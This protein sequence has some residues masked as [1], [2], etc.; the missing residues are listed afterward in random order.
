M[1]TL[2]TGRLVAVAENASAATESRLAA[3]DAARAKHERALI[4]LEQQRRLLLAKTNRGSNTIEPQPD[5]S[6]QIPFDSIPFSDITS[7]GMGPLMDVEVVTASR[8]AESREEAPNVIYVFTH[9]QIKQRGYKFIKDILQV[10]PGFHV[11][12]STDY[13]QSIRG[14]AP[15]D[16]EKLTLMINGHIINGL[17]E[18]KFLDG[19]INFD[20][21]ERVEVIVGP[22]SVLYGPETTGGIVNLITR[23]PSSP[24]VHLTAGNHSFQSHTVLY[25]KQWDEDKSYMVSGSYVRQ[26]GYKQ[27]PSLNYHAY[28]NVGNTEIGGLRYPSHL[29]YAQAQMGETWFQFSSYYGN[30]PDLAITDTAISL[31]EDPFTVRRNDFVNS[32]LVRDNTSLTSDLSLHYEVSFDNKRFS[33]RAERTEIWSGAPNYD[34]T[35]N[36][37]GIEVGVKHQSEKNYLQAGIQ[38][39]YKEN[40]HNYVFHWDPSDP[41]KNSYNR[42]LVEIR[43]TQAAG[44]YISDEYAMHDKVKLVG[45]C[46]F[47]FDTTLDSSKVYISPRAA[48]IF[49]PKEAW[50]S[51]LMYNR[52]TRIPSPWMTPMNN[53]W[54]NG[55]PNA[56]LY[57]V[58]YSINPMAEHPEVLDAYEWQNIF[59]FDQL[60]TSINIYYQKLK[61]VVTWYSPYSNAGDFDGYG[62]EADATYQ[63]NPKMKIWGNLAHTQAEFSARDSSAQLPFAKNDN[64]EPLSVPFLT[65]N[66]GTDWYL[67]DN[68]HL[69]TT[70]R[71]FTRQPAYDRVTANYIYISNQFYLDTTLAWEGALHDNLDIYLTGMNLLNNRNY[72][73]Q[74]YVQGMYKPR[75]VSIYLSAS[76]RFK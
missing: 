45:A 40:S 56:S 7:M 53:L 71:Y 63:L 4:E 21:V 72:V 28:P 37:Y 69:S 34:L 39:K 61:D 25:A 3:I 38:Y 47:D 52:A 9:E 67:S 13:V 36:I 57:P 35:Q 70:L 51:K 43:D 49:R 54:G 10:V 2:C 42:N 8:K 22:G 26:D 30:V 74:Q 5:S 17:S 65:S 29:L 1:L 73:S 33:R 44:F 24:E 68:L 64:G 48:V 12:F 75:G 59:Y 19:P 14:I 6:T 23:T 55:N 16:N 31:G 11:S 15:M 32:F 66:V 20:I 27:D 76:Y 60:R 62:I 41:S 18:P 50:T 58:S 46:R